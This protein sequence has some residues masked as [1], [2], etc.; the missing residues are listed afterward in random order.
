MKQH[1]VLFIS[2]IINFI[3]ITGIIVT[4][5]TTITTGKTSNFS[6]HSQLLKDKNS[7]TLIMQ[8]DSI[9]Y[10]NVKN[11]EIET[12]K[13]KDYKNTSYMQKNEKGNSL[14]TLKIDSGEDTDKI[15]EELAVDASDIKFKINYKLNKEPIIIKIVEVSEKL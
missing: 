9:P 7:V 8:T 12:D 11:F 10:H 14:F 1:K 6:I 2:L 5:I 15:Y 4:S 13:Y 3:L